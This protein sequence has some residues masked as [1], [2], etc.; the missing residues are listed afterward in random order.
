MRPGRGEFPRAFFLP[1]TPSPG[2]NEGPSART[3]CTERRPARGAFRLT[4]Q[5]HCNGLQPPARPPERARKPRSAEKRSFLCKQEQ[6]EAVNTF[7]IFVN[8]S[9]TERREKVTPSRAGAEQHLAEKPEHCRQEPNGALKSALPFANEGRT[10][11]R[12]NAVPEQGRN[13]ASARAQRSPA[14][15]IPSFDTTARQ[16]RDGVGLRERV[17]STRSHGGR[18]PNAASRNIPHPAAIRYGRPFRPLPRAHSFPEKDATEPTH[19][20]ALPIRARTHSRR[21]PPCRPW[22]SG[23]DYLPRETLFSHSS[24]RRGLG[25]SPGAF[26]AATHRRGKGY[27]PAAGF[28]RSTSPERRAARFAAMRSSGQSHQRSSRSFCTTSSAKRGRM[29]RA[30]TPPTMA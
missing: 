17:R 18:R 10:E 3:R 24:A 8:K 16:R 6:N 5:V 25:R 26:S 27:A 12:A 29:L 1:G 14:L 19:K 15:F 23:G 21:L 28:N 22:G 4:P 7:C 20:P 2:W 13:N 11:R 9:R 30:G